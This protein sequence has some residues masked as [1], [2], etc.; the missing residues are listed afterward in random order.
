MR[1][2]FKKMGKK[3]DTLKKQIETIKQIHRRYPTHEMI[4]RLARE[5][6]INLMGIPKNS[7]TVIF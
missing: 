5:N 3:F 7:Q 2:S 1:K 4:G 6:Y